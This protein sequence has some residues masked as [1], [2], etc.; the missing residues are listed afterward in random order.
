VVIAAISL[1]VVAS[2][3]TRNAA[4]TLPPANTV[5][6]SN[7]IAEDTVVGSGAFQPMLA[8]AVRKETGK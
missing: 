4:A 2:A 6:Q 1:A 3:G 7:K 5:A 8:P